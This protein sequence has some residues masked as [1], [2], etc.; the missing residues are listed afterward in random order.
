[1]TDQL[2]KSDGVDPGTVLKHIMTERRDDQI[3]LSA[4]EFVP[5][6]RGDLHWV[7][8]KWRS[9]V[10][11]LP[12]V[13]GGRELVDSRHAVGILPRQ[14]RQDQ[15]EFSWQWSGPIHRHADP[16]SNNNPIVRQQNNP[17]GTVAL[18]GG[19]LEQVEQRVRNLSQSTNDVRSLRFPRRMARALA[20]MPLF[21]VALVVFSACGKA[22]F[23]S[24]FRA[25][26]TATHELRIA[27]D[28]AAIDANRAD[29][30]N[31]ALVLAEERART[32]GLDARRI[33]SNAEVGLL[34]SSNTDDATD[35]GAAL[36]TLINSLSP[37]QGVAP[38]APFIGT[39]GQDSPALGGNEYQLSLVVDGAL[40]QDAFNALT[41]DLVG[42]GL[43]DETPVAF[44]VTYQATMPG[45]IKE[46]DGESIDNDTVRWALP[47][48]AV[49][50]VNAVSSVGKTTPWLLVLG[51]TLGISALIGVVALLVL[52]ILSRRGRPPAIAGPLSAPGATAQPLPQHWPAIKDALAAAV[53]RALR[54][55]SAVER[56]DAK[57][58]QLTAVDAGKEERDGTHAQGD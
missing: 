37:S 38:V 30:V 13:G 25:S 34:V 31:E 14:L 43:I 49:T 18:R 8:D 51:T 1:M 12:G 5:E 52:R 29:A 3:D 24:T 10:A 58:A 39:F 32:G 2:T 11:E 42:T 35:T 41:A 21:V 28:R 55:G 53:A 6:D 4:A 44:E 15:R 56:D 26:G 17:Y 54:G 16:P 19:L 57:Q 7:L 48:N 36:N 20:M 9:L 22:S 45:D 27:V 46:S 50:E 23:G 47:L 40:L 33:G